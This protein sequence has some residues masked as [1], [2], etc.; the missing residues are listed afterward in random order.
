[1]TSGSGPASP[2]WLEALLSRIQALAADR[3]RLEEV[4]NTLHAR[5]L[6]VIH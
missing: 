1:M 6:Q 5:L 2:E 3:A 4:N